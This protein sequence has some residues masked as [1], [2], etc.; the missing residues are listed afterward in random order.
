MISE[1]EITNFK[2]FSG[3]EVVPIRPIT[4]IYGVNSSGK[5]CILQ[6]LLLLKQT[7]EESVSPGTALLPTGNLVDLGSYHDF[8]NA[9]DLDKSVSF[10]MV[11]PLTADDIH[12]LYTQEEYNEIDSLID[13]LPK[14]LDPPIVGLRTSFSYDNRSARVYLAG[15]DLFLGDDREPFLTAGARLRNAGSAV[16]AE[17]KET[18]GLKRRGN[19]INVK[20]VNPNHKFWGRYWENY[21]DDLKVG[22]RE[23]S[24]TLEFDNDGDEAFPIIVPRDGKF[25]PNDEDAQLTYEY[26]E[27]FKRKAEGEE[28]PCNTFLPTDRQTNWWSKSESHILKLVDNASRKLR[29]ALTNLIYLG[30]LRES[31]ER[32]YISSASPIEY[33]GKSGE[34]VP[35]ML[36]QDPDLVEHLSK[37]LDRFDLGYDEVK[38][39]RLA[40]GSSEPTGLFELRLVEKSTGVAVSI[41]DVGF[42]VSQILPI[43]LQGVL[44]HERTI[45]IEQPEIHIHPRLQAELGV[46]SRTFCKL[47]RLWFLVLIA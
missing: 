31:P 37:V 10:K 19:C 28:I 8:V 47:L 30:P 20:T 21:K 27:D 25:S 43:I 15:S 2:A 36:F 33:V 40:S 39:S 16:K 11:M 44:S 7:L 29:L 6:S 41:P 24:G 22:Q 5:S 34:S 12:V 32:Y 3:P 18:K 45:C 14:T 46:V 26:F 13:E 35:Y 23:R 42:G 4:L 1:L 17:K 9:H 38:V